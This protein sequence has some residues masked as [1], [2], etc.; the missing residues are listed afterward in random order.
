MRQGMGRHLNA[1]MD[2]E[3]LQRYKFYIIT[4]IP[5]STSAGGHIQEL[6]TACPVRQVMSV[7]DPI[8]TLSQSN[9]HCRNF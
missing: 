1:M 5:K 6:R 7:R 8:A 3:L 9:N 2:V 4:T